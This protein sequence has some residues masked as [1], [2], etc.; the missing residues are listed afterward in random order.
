VRRGEGAPG[1]QHNKAS[2]KFP[3]PF[4][5]WLELSTMSSGRRQDRKRRRG[6]EAG[7]EEAKATRARRSLWAESGAAGTRSPEQRFVSRRNACFGLPESVA[8]TGR[9]QKLAVEGEL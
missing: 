3:D 9:I 8:T 4:G 2:S 5:A 6:A 1:G 7:V